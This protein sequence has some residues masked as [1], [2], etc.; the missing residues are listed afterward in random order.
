MEWKIA[1]KMASCDI[2]CRESGFTELNLLTRGN[3][4]YELLSSKRPPPTRP[5]AYAKF[6]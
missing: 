6:T 4:S 2:P 1:N 5:T 3:S